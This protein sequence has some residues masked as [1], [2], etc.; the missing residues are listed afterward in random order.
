MNYNLE[1]YIHP[2]KTLI[3]NVRSRAMNINTLFRT[4]FGSNHDAVVC[5]CGG[6]IFHIY[7]QLEKKPQTVVN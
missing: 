3:N 6:G 4:L 1:Y 2:L 5:V 7:A